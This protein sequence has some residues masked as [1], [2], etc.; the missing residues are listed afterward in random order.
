MLDK[1][2]YWD[3]RRL[4]PEGP[5]PLL[6]ITK[7]EF[8][9]WWSANVAANISSLNWSC[10][11]VWLVWDDDNSKIFS[12][13]CR[14][15]NV[16]FLEIISTSPTITKQ[17]FIENTYK[18]QLLRVDYEHKIELDSASLNKILN[19][20]KNKRY[21]YI[22]ISDYNKWIITQDLVSSLKNV[23]VKILVDSKPKNVEFFMNTFLVKPNFKEFCDMIGKTIDNK[24]CEIEKYWSEFVKKMKTNLVIT[25]WKEG[26]SVITKNL[27][28][29]HIETFAREVFDVTWA[30]DT[31]IATIAYAL[32]NWYTLIDAVKLWNKASWIV[33]WK[34]WTEIIKKEELF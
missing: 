6:N 26:A 12:E 28:Y 21:E 18:Q 33:I 30:W 4:N 20:V 8:R 25:R 3:V 7:E 19:I 5:N 15:K 13:L 24:D 16:N 10:D 9:L 17:R 27:E 31:F 11:L 1:Y 23:D 14:Q 34:T 2:S 29:F 22:I 32:W